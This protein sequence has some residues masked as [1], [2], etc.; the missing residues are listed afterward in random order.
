[1][2]ITAEGINREV[3]ATL[4]CATLCRQHQS[5]KSL[6]IPETA[7]FKL[8]SRLPPTND[9]PSRQE[10]LFGRQVVASTEYRPTWKEIARGILPSL[11]H[12]VKRDRK[13]NDCDECGSTKRRRTITGIALTVDAV[14]DRKRD[15]SLHSID[16]HGNDYFCKLCDQELSNPYFHCGG[17]EKLLAKDFNICSQC[18][19]ERKFLQNILMHTMTETTMASNFHHVGETTGGCDCGDPIA[20]LACKKC[21]LCSC[22][23]HKKFAKK[24][25]F[26]TEARQE[27]IRK[28]CEELVGDDEIKYARE[29]ECR[30]DGVVMVPVSVVPEPSSPVMEQAT[31]EEESAAVAAGDVSLSDGD[32]D[33]KPTAAET[34]LSRANRLSPPSSSQ[35]QESCVQAVWLN[36]RDQRT[37]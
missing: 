28:G 24:F 2:G 8:A 13:A 26:F 7:I 4:E 33:R 16:P 1:M 10:P 27:E 37:L 36:S 31:M 14:P 34:G 25:R 3:A 32:C 15:P 9:Q 5:S 21:D 11:N 19:A 18:F 29:T 22:N 17:C 23:C 20:C 30:L 6:A 12:V 35:K